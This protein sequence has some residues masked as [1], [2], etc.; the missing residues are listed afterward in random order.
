MRANIYSAKLL[1]LATP[2]LLTLT[3]FRRAVRQNVNV[4]HSTFRE[5]L[6]RVFETMDRESTL[7]PA[8]E[9]LYR[10]AKYPLAVLADDIVLHSG[11]AHATEWAKVSLLESKFFGSNVGGEVLFERATE[12]RPDQVELATIIYVAICL[13]VEGQYHDRPGELEEIKTKLFRLAK[14]GIQFNSD[15]LTPGAY[16]YGPGRVRP[17]RRWATHLGAVLIGL[18]LGLVYWGATNDWMNDTFRKISITSDSS[19]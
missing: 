3:S 4:D 13:G 12:L 14:E 8:L 18:I 9:A 16:R 10:E 17:N 5:E 1:E 2:L 11:W 19:E 7:D 15:R 6:I